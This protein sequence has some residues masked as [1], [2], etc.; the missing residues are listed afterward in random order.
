MM[1]FSKS[2]PAKFKQKPRRQSRGFFMR[3]SVAEF[4]P[5]ISMPGGG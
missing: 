2:H 1:W 4:A 3:Q 5:P